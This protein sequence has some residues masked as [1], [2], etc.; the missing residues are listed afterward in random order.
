M[1]FS[2]FTIGQDL[3]IMKSNSKLIKWK[4]LQIS[5][6]DKKIHLLKFPKPI[7]MNVYS[8]SFVPKANIWIGNR[9]RIMLLSIYIKTIFL[10]W[11]W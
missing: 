5:I 7:Q 3:N 6:F 4:F 8:T 10:I 9:K 2:K 1:V 11:G